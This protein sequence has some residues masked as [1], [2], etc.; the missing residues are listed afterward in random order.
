MANVSLATAP[1][2]AFVGLFGI[3]VGPSDQV[4]LVL[5]KIAGEILGK[6][7]DSFF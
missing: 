3:V 1:I 7:V 2:L 4:Y 6:R 5:T